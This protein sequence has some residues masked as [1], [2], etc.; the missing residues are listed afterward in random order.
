ME[1]MKIKKRVRI[2]FY[3]QFT[4]EYTKDLD[5]LNKIIMLKFKPIKKTRHH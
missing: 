5:D 4:E 3:I 1:N 2:I